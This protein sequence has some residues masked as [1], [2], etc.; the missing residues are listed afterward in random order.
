MTPHSVS[1]V[2]SFRFS[3]SLLT[4]FSLSSRYTA[5]AWCALKFLRKSN[6]HFHARLRVGVMFHHAHS[7]SHASGLL[8]LSP[9][10]ICLNQFLRKALVL[11]MRGNSAA[12]GSGY[13]VFR[14][15]VHVRGD[16]VR[17]TVLYSLQQRVKRGIQISHSALFYFCPA[18]QGSQPKHGP[19][20][21]SKT[22][23]SRN[24]PE[25]PFLNI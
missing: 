5:P 14:L 25:Y 23:V 8:V 3:P 9:T 13:I 18:T 4:F 2:T 7:G 17:P 20:D 10:I 24:C 11:G 12:F 19:V 16:D 22:L 1:T 15:H 6:K 21:D